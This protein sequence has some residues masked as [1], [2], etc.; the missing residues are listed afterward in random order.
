MEISCN[1]D[2]LEMLKYPRVYRATMTCEGL[3]VDFEG[4]EDVLRLR[5]GEKVVLSINKGK[6]ECLAHEFCGRARVVSI[7]RMDDGSYRAVLSIGGLLV[8]LRSTDRPEFD[9]M[10]EVFVGLSR[11]RPE[12]AGT[13]AD[14]P[15]LSASPD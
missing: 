11:L 2:G 9:V 8:V 12:Q 15:T 10:D 13:F 6:E 3:R 1:V 7:R 5:G 14:G 4:H